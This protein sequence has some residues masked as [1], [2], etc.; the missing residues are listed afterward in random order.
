MIHLR[1]C[2]ADDLDLL[3][4]MNKQLIEDEGAGNSMDLPQLKNRMAEFL[5]NGYQGF[6]FFA[7][8]DAVG[9]GL[10]DPTTEPVYVRQFFI[11]R[12]ERRKHYGQAAFRE[13]LKKLKTGTVEIDVYAWNRT[14]EQFWLSL[15][16]TGQWKR[17]RYEE[18]Q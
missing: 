16:F 13:L 12:G 4:E 8:N 2:S 15:G 3:A 14:G 6:L 9:Y 1:E 18:K 5:K 10:C 7:G 17:M 11:K